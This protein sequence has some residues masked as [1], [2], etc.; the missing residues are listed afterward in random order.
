MKILLLSSLICSSAFSADGMLDQTKDALL[1][2]KLVKERTNFFARR[3]E[4]KL[5]G[6]YSKEFLLVTPLITGQVEFNT[7]DIKFYVNARQE[8]GGMEYVYNF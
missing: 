2:Y 6:Q 4:K 7:N 8:I 3:L 5:L 1:S